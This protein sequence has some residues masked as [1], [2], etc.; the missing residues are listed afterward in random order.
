MAHQYQVRQNHGFC[1]TSVIGLGH[2]EGRSMRIFISLRSTSCSSNSSDCCRAVVW[3]RLLCDD[4]HVTFAWPHQVEVLGADPTVA[5]EASKDS[6][7]ASL[8]GVATQSTASILNA[9]RCNTLLLNQCDKFCG[10]TH[11]QVKIYQLLEHCACQGS[12]S[13][14]THGSSAASSPA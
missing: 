10:V 13:T 12:G 1:K 11:S 2:P 4:S 6:A 14:A 3:E 8:D 9:T 5:H 7:R